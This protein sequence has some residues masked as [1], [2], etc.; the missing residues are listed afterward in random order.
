M[1]LLAALAMQTPA[2]RGVPPAMLYRI[3]AS[4]RAVGLESEARL[5]AAEAIARA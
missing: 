2:W 1:V 5:I 4:L 3:I